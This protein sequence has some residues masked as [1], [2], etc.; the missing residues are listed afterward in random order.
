M[1]LFDVLTHDNLEDCRA[2]LERHP[3][4]ANSEGWHGITPLHRAATRGN[5]DACKLL[6]QYGAN[7]NKVNGFGETPLHY[8]CQ[9]ASLR[10]VN[11]LVEN[12]ADF[13]VLDNGGRSCIHHAARSGSIWKIH[14]LVA[15]GLSL[16]KRDNRGQTVLHIAA[17]HGHI[18]LLE[19]CLRNQRFQ[20]GEVDNSQLTPLHIAA[21]HSNRQ[22]AWI[23][24]SSSSQS[25]VNLRDIHGKTPIDHAAEGVTR[26]H[27]WLTTHLKYWQ[28]SRCG[29]YRPSPWF[30]WILLLLCPSLIIYFV[31]WCLQE[32]EQSTGWLVTVLAIAIFYSWALTAHRMRHISALPSP[33]FAG[34]FFGVIIQSLICY[35]THI[36][37]AIW[38]ELLWTT[39]SVLLM[40]AVVTSLINLFSD[41]GIVKSPRLKP[42]GSPYTIIDVAEGKVPVEEFCYHCELVAPIFSKH[43]RLCN[44]CVLAIDHHCL[45]LMCCVGYKNHRAF[46][47]FMSLVLLSQMLFVRAAV[48]Y[49]LS[50]IR[51]DGSYPSSFKEAL[52][53]DVYVS[54][55]LTINVLGFYY[56]FLLTLY[57]L[58]IVSEG[59]TTYYSPD[60]KPKTK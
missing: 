46:V 28:A 17:E 16:T 19:Y 44:H 7:V 32:L 33:T 43:C 51:T 9:A 27:K 15:L 40:L 22:C 12:G 59:A 37:P 23:L 48:T 10:F 41:P 35:Y 25:L 1:A 34:L 45:F 24:E 58:K 21:Q 3:A 53:Y 2:I 38:P 36:V 30:P 13:N 39:M 42:D 18:D 26:E 20:P 60:G 4:T 50:V 56:V 55:L 47:V 54:V 14:Y 5:I 31:I 11:V 49:L 29:G 6:I 8:A 57:Q 52:G